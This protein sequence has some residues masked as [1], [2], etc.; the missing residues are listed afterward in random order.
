MAIRHIREAFD[1]EAAGQAFCQKA[2]LRYEDDGKGGQHQIITLI[3]NTADGNAFTLSTP[4]HAMSDDPHAHARALARSLKMDPASAEG[5]GE[6]PPTTGSSETDP[7]HHLGESANP[8]PG[9]GG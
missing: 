3:G 4:A 8:I 5:A 1:Q 6:R 9:A 7:Q 2:T